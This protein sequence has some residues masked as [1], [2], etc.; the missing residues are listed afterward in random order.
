MWP[1]VLC[2]MT[3]LGYLATRSTPPI[4]LLSVLLGASDVTIAIAYGERD[5]ARARRTIVARLVCGLALS[6]GLGVAHWLGH[7]ASAAMLR[8][9]LTLVAIVMAI[10]AHVAATVDRPRATR[11][12]LGVGAFVLLLDV[13]AIVGAGVAAAEHAR[14]FDDSTARGRLALALAMSVG[15]LFFVRALIV[16]AIDVASAR[17][18]TPSPSPMQIAIVFVA[19]LGVASLAATIAGVVLAWSGLA[20]AIVLALASII[21]EGR[22][23]TRQADVALTR[24]MLGLIV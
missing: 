5:G 21:V 17:P 4:A 23:R 14:L 22:R 8:W 13:A 12:R 6:A 7:A 9:A 2:T 15:G 10:A 11:A 3:A 1:G 19:W 24:A 20:A 16:R 18:S